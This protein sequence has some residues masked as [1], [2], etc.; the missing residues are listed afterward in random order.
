MHDQ[1]LEQKLRAALQ[2]DGDGL[3]FTI[4]AAELERRQAPRRRG[5]LGRLASLGL[6]AVVGILLVGLVGVAGGWFEQ[7]TAITPPVSPSPSGPDA[8]ASPSSGIARDTLP[9]LDELIGSRDPAT[10]VRAQSVG[11]EQGPDAGTPPDPRSVQFAPVTATGTYAVDLA[12]I[13]SVDLQLQVINGNPDIPGRSEPFSCDRTPSSRLVDLVAGDSLGIKTSGS[14]SWRIVVEAPA[15]T[16]SDATTIDTSFG[17]PAGDEQLT[18]LASNTVEPT[19]VGSPAPIDTIAPIEVGS[20]APRRSYRVLTSCA[21][22]GP[23][24]YLFGSRAQDGPGGINA[25]STTAVACDGAMHT[26]DLG[27]TERNGAQIYVLADPRVVWRVMVASEIPPVS[28][29]ADDT[30]WAMREATGPTVQLADRSYSMSSGLE[31]AERDI[32]VVVS[33]LGGTGVEVTVYDIDTAQTAVG[34]FHVACGGSDPVTVAKTFTL[35]HPGYIVEVQ[36]TGEMWLAA[37]VQGRVPASPA[38]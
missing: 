21:G 26:D 14:P 11:P 30:R 5:G 2:A 17:P 13:G 9:T 12:C 34:S 29:A 7:R 8:S 31:G 19:W 23:V 25:S 37:T 36:P 18:E 1:S 35:R 28:V 24:R 38:P 6:A 10:I 16:R 22:P 27:L 20:V 33:C 15:G 32:R 4:T 3:A